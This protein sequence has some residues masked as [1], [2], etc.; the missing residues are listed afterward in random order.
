MGV[1]KFREENIKVLMDISQAPSKATY[2]S[3]IND[4]I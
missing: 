3:I 1:G 2:T 4:S